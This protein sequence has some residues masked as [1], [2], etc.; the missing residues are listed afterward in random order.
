MTNLTEDTNFSRGKGDG[1]ALA[2]T[3]MKTMDDLRGLISTLVTGAKADEA[4]H[5][6]AAQR[7]VLMGALET[8]DWKLVKPGTQALSIYFTEPTL[9]GLL[10][11][12]DLNFNATH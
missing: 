8:F 3:R 10:R 5:K 2:V 1:W 6:M 9:I 7:H 4:S 11:Y 12:L